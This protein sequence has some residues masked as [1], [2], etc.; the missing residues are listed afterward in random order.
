ME[1]LLRGM[2]G[3]LVADAHMNTIVGL[4]NSILEVMGTLGGD[5]RK[6]RLEEPGSGASESPKKTSNQDMGLV[7]YRTPVRWWGMRF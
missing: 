1:V 7:N 2:G 6:R 3:G 4:G 5:L